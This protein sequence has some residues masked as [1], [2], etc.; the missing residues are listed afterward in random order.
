MNLEGDQF[1]EKTRL[2]RASLL[3]WF[4][5]TTVLLLIPIPVGL[6]EIQASTWLPLDKVAHLGLFGVAAVLSLLN[7][8]SGRSTLAAWAIYGITIEVIQE[9]TGY[10]SFEWLDFLSDLAGV[11]IGMTI[12]WAATGVRIAMSDSGKHPVG[13]LLGVRVDAVYR[14][15]LMDR[16]THAAETGNGG[17]ITNVNVHAM[18]IA[19]KDR[20]FRSILNGSDLV[21]VDGAGVRLAAQLSSVQ[22]GE[23]L[24]AADW[25]DEVFEIC[26]QREWPIFW[27]GDTDKVGAEFESELARRQPK[28]PFAGR[29][30]GFFA[31]SGAE[32][33][34]VVDLINRSGAR[35]LLVGM[36]MPLQE[37]WIWANRHRLQVPVMLTVGGLARVYIGDIR[38]G[39]RWMTDNGLEWLFRLVMQP[40]YTWRRYVIG[41]PLFMLRVILVR[42][43]IL[44]V[45][46]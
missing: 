34:A 8:L 30:H 27:L 21:F 1:I 31:K 42:M 39:P 26:A 25:I 5:F 46:E 6:N 13:K 3:L 18:N 9:A 15:D 40:Q 16:I 29:H 36:S 19:W 4:L 24:T 35:I 2:L 23:R 28:C 38:R 44:K 17:L 43:G 10:R 41:N 45:A 33:D 7:G 14:A 22:V 11:S 20:E 37:K 32:N 12:F